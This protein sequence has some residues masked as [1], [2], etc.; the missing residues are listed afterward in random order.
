MHKYE[1]WPPNYFGPILQIV[2]KKPVCSFSPLKLP[3]G[4]CTW[5]TN[6]YSKK[7]TFQI[8]QCLLFALH[9]EIHCIHAINGSYSWQTFTCDSKAQQTLQQKDLLKYEEKN[10][11]WLK[12]WMVT[13]PMV[14]FHQRPMKNHQIQKKKQYAYSLPGGI[15]NH[16]IQI[17]KKIKVYL[18]YWKTIKYKYKKNA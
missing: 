16:Q 2:K 15:K 6:L 11:R 13:L 7:I 8:V 12:R 3:C 5:E 1:V 17:Q 4:A 10:L 9:N 14:S 18:V